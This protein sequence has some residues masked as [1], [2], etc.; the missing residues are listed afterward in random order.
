VIKR[1]KDQE[2]QVSEYLLAS[3]ESR[4]TLEKFESDLVRGMSKLIV[5]SIIKKFGTEGLYGYKIIKE[6]EILTNK[7]FILE[8][9]HLYPLLR[10]LKK[11]GL[12]KTMQKTVQGRNRTYYSITNPQGEQF[13]NR[14][15]GFFSK[16]TEALGP[17]FD[18]NVDIYP[19]KYFFCPECANKIDL[20]NLEYKF[21][22][23]C[24]YNIENELK[25]R[26][27]RK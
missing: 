4:K 2:D 27:L 16:L 17:L 20:T 21:C 9:G 13:Y 22:V 18:V 19:E 23:V 12:L 14:M 6:L 5:L 8:E 3:K 10:K 11:D 25:E 1:I 24:G 15:V 26:G 7:I